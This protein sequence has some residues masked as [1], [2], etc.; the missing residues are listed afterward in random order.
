M[1][2]LLLCLLAACATQTSEDRAPQGLADPI[3]DDSP[4]VADTPDTDLP[5]DDTA[6]PTDTAVPDGWTLLGSMRPSTCEPSGLCWANVAGVGDRLGNLSALGPDHA[7]MTSGDHAA[8]HYQ[9]GVWSR[10]DFDDSLL[11]LAANADA[12]W[13][14]TT[15]GLYR[16]T[17]SRV[18]RAPVDLPQGYSLVAV[19]PAGEVVLGGQAGALGFDGADLVSIGMTDPLESLFWEHTLYGEGWGHTWWHDGR[20][21]QEGPTMFLVSD[22]SEPTPGEI[23]VASGY[24][25]L[26]E[27]DVLAPSVTWHGEYNA[28]VAITPTHQWL[29]GFGREVVDRLTGTVVEAAGEIAALDAAG[30]D[31]LAAGAGGH[32]SRVT[33][34][35]DLNPGTR[36]DRV[37]ELVPLGGDDLLAVCS[38][39]VLVREGGLWTRHAAPADLPLYGGAH[40]DGQTWLRSRDAIVRFDAGAFTDRADV[41]DSALSDIAIDDA[42]TV[43]VTTWDG[44][45]RL[46][47][48]GLVRDGSADIDGPIVGGHDRMYAAG[49]QRVWARDALGWQLLP[50][51]QMDDVTDLVATADG[52]VTINRFEAM[53]WDGTAW[54]RIAPSAI[55]PE[56]VSGDPD[57]T[58]WIGTQSGGALYEVVGEVIVQSHRGV[59]NRTAMATLDDGTFVVGT[60]GGTIATR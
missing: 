46:T 17:P 5:G 35:T 55:R 28:L 9:D 15:D 8:V 40:R 48:D 19:S 37:H 33:D 54:R 42:G 34:G 3:D 21:W 13:A 18:E 32:L 52:V 41:T 22:V 23:W 16:L 38:Q 2:P 24:S 1:R 10:W 44:A 60:H 36:C 57:G 49:G 53:R 43:W 25:G 11:D 56:R 27:H 58:L 47:A 30:T 51:A 7:W 12:A 31:V 20:A 45:F 50:A 39:E 26:V 14:L 59:A 4:V 29:A 6:V